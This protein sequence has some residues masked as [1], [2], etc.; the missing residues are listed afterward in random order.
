MIV[1]AKLQN[2]SLERKK[3]PQNLSLK[4][5]NRHKSAQQLEH[6]EGNMVVMAC[7]MATEGIGCGS[8][9]HGI[10]TVEGVL[11]AYP[12]KTGVLNNHKH[13]GGRSVANRKMI[14]FLYL[15][16]PI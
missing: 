6:P 12:D 11:S 13:R 3:K 2:F 5:K 9:P 15:C 16:S 14:F 10:R 1:G 4:R 8:A 7:F